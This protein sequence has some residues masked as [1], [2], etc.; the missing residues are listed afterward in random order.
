MEKYSDSYLH[1]DAIHLDKTLGCIK[2][3]KMRTAKDGQWVKSVIFNPNELKA[4]PAWTEKQS[5]LG[6]CNTLADFENALTYWANIS[7]I[8]SNIPLSFVRLDFAFDCHTTGKALE[9]EERIFQAIVMAFAAKHD[10]KPKDQTLSTTF[11]DRAWKSHKTEFRQLSLEAYDRRHKCPHSPVP[12]RLEI[13]YGARAKYRPRHPKTIREMLEIIGTELL[14]LR[15]QLPILEARLN[16]SLLREY[17]TIELGMNEFIRSNA[18]RIFTRRQLETLYAQLDPVGGRKKAE[19]RAK[20]QLEWYKS[21]FHIINENGYT[22]AIDDCLNALQAYPTNGVQIYLLED[23][24][25]SC[26]PCNSTAPAS[27]AS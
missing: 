23:L 2:D 10:V 26:S 4:R 19:G 12:L 8:G 27:A 25:K 13:R 21:V 14:G 16:Q 24:L 9:V 18:D 17:A 15:D 7:N 1:L 5:P 20:H 6:D 22:R 3:E 11:F